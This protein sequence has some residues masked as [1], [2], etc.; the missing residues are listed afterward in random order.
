MELADFRGVGPARVAALRAMGICSL[1]D[2]LFTMPIR[3]EDHD[4]VTPCAEGR[5]GVCL[6]EGSFRENLKTAWFHGISRTSGV[7]R[8]ASGSVPVC[9]FNEPW[10]ARAIPPGKSVRLYGRVNVNQGRRVLQNPRVVT[11][12]GMVPVYRAVSGFPAK[13]FRALIGEALKYVEEVC[14]ETLPDSFRARYGLVTS[15]EALRQI[16]FPSS[17]DQLA[18]AER[19]IA[20]ERVLNYLLY[21]TLTGARREPALPFCLDSGA[22]ETFWSALPFSPTG[23]QRRV[24]SEIAE[25]LGRDVAMRRLVQGD[26]GSGKTAVAFGAIWLA[27]QAHH[28]AVMM[29]PT[30]ILAR[31]HYQT[32]L[33]TLSPLGVRC[34]LLTGST[35]AAERRQIL[36]ELEDHTCDA[37]F[38]THAVISPSVRYADLQLAITD[39]QHRFGVNQRTGLEGKGVRSEEEGEPHPHVL[40]MSAT[41]IPRTLALIL[42]GDLDISVI[43]Q[44]PAGRIPVKTRLVPDTRRED[45]YRFLRSQTA[46]GR[47]AYVVCPL[48]EDSESAGEEMKS[49]KTVFA[50]LSEGALK[51][52]RVALTWGGQKGEEKARILE[53]FRQGEYDVLIATTVIEVGVNNPNAT[54]MIV[55][56]AERF[57]LSQ[58]HQL[59]GRVGRGSA[60]SWCFLLAGST[61]KLQILCQTNDGFEVARKD[62]EQRGP[63]DLAGVRQ[64]GSPVSDVLSGDPRL[65]AEVS[66]CVRSLRS[67]PVDRALLETLENNARQYFD[68]QGLHIAYN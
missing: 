35:R 50:D 65:L 38:G 36:K 16:H 15:S 67:R 59:R 68:G 42:Y 48:V 28:Q 57:G 41:P 31:Q 58:L 46:A 12:S 56:N 47:Q 19:R 45:M 24:M 6:M 52:L 33:E 39:E 29:A 13:S 32:A 61:E 2:L 60:E 7:L 66:E 26:V 9:W 18:A 22:V 1:R 20:F 63:G 51:G 4:T 44:M 10:I 14:P 43:D 40:V 25:D 37:L 34:R 23:A 11:D 30:E 53:G 21:V 3:Y 62:L 5:V 49:A 17:P 64:S 55:E 8:D 54:I 27:F